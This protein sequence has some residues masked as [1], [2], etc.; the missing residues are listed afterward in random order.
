MFHR[1][2]EFPAF[3]VTNSDECP[4]LPD[5]RE[6]KMFTIAHDRSSV[7]LYDALAKN[8]FRRSQYALYKPACPNCS[9]CLSAR[10]R[11]SD[12]APTNSQRRILS[13][14]RR[15]TRRLAPPVADREQFE[16]FRK[17]VRHRHDNGCMAEMSAVEYM[18][19]V[20]ESAV[21]TWL[22]LY[23]DAGETPGANQELVAAC[24]TDHMDD[25]VSMVYSYFDPKKSVASLGTYMVLDHVKIVQA[26]RQDLKYVYLGYWIPKSEKM[27]YKSRF[28]ALEVLRNGVWTDVGNPDD[29]T[30]DRF[31]PV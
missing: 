19:M 7:A 5:R 2:N 17:Y 28:S 3:H 9:A 30:P 22:V 20:E 8:G 16:L 15:L 24:I 27:G 23:V 6:R 26:A 10:I 1:Q 11:A 14:N 29:Y 18:D 31:P 4:Y 12:F 25:G 13:R 21:R